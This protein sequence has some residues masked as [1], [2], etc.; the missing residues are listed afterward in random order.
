M[1]RSLRIAEI[2]ARADP[3]YGAC[4]QG[5]GMKHYE[6]LLLC[7]LAGGVVAGP[8]PGA[9]QSFQSYRCAD[10]TEFVA[11]FYPSDSRAHLQIDGQPVTLYRRLSLSGVRYA[12]EGIVL[13]ISRA[14]VTT[15]RHAR[16]PPTACDLK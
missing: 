11:G 14:G 9:A 4:Y 3:V 6:K 8:T 15:V 16:R 12:G 1:T 10:G 2:I 7:A 5:A 13:R